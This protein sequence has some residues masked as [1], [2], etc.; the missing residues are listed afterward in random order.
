MRV[1]HRRSSEPSSCRRSC[2]ARSTSRSATP[3]P[4]PAPTSRRCSTR[5]ERDGDEWVINGQKIYTSLAGYADYVWLAGRTDPDAPKHKGISIIIVPTD[6]AR[7]LVHADPHHGRRRHHRD[8]LRGRARARPV[9]VGDENGGWTLI[10]NQLNH[11]RV[12]LCRPGLVVRRINDTLAWA[13]DTTLAD[14]RR[15]IDQEWVQV[16]LARIH[17]RLEFLKLLNWKVA[18]AATET[19]SRPTR[20]ATKVFGTE[21]YIE[22][23]RLLMEVIGQA[24]TLR[25]GSPAAVAAGPNRA[26]L[27]GHAR[28]HLRRRHQRGAARP[29]RACSASACRACRVDAGAPRWTSHLTRRPDARLGELAAQHPRR[30]GCRPSAAS[31]LEPATP[32]GSRATPGP[33][34]PS[35]GLLGAALPEAVRRRRA[36]LPR[37]AARARGDRPRRSRRC[38]A[39]PR[40]SSARCRSRRFGTDGAAARAAARRDRR[41][42]GADRGAG[43]GRRARR[44]PT[45]R[46]PR[47]RARRRRLRARR[48]RS[49]SSRP[50]TSPTARPRARRAPTTARRR[51]PR[52]PDGAEGVTRRARRSPRA[53]SRS[54]RSSLDGVAVAADDVARRPGDGGA[55]AAGSPS[56]RRRRL[57]RCSAG[58]CEEA[59][60]MTAAHV[61]ERE[62]FGQP[63]ATFQAVAQRAADAYIDTRGD[64]AHRA[65][66]RRGG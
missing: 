4:A 61:S 24:A 13:R 32:T 50:R 2:A 12:S 17:A 59:L 22:A 11:E 18:W 20:R 37:G 47:A 58:V 26:S 44:S 52:R 60:R 9:L 15:V 16:S 19:G 57:R 34:S 41:R 25:R 40:S 49:S 39:S 33:S 62:Q 10:T 28:P 30:Q 7:L 63:I 45:R 55:I 38:R 48:R 14:G 54:A 6:D 65:G 5:A 42:D 3:S 31:Q 36:R 35:A 66:R 23:Y 8:L 51:V 64:R 1:R 27:P 56:A 29:D 46:A 53:A 43:R 21:F